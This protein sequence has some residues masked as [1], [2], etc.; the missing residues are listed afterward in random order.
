LRPRQKRTAM[1]DVSKD[2]EFRYYLKEILERYKLDERNASSMLATIHSKARMLSI[3]D[4]KDYVREKTEEGI[5]PEDGMVEILR[6]LNR[7]RKWR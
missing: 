6:L 2:R 7:F 4:A 1:L 5:L 3:S